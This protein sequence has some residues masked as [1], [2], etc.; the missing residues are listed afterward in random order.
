MTREEHLTWCKERAL[1]YVDAGD[2]TNAV[3]SMCSDIEKHEETQGNPAVILGPIMMM[4]HPTTD[5][6]R[7][8]IE[9]FN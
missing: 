8:F 1:E 5:S 7:R 9:G 6:V 3:A 2:L 4:G